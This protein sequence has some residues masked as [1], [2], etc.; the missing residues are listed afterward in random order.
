MSLRR[1]GADPRCD[2]DRALPITILIGS[3]PAK[4]FIDIFSAF[5]YYYI[6]NPQSPQMKG[7]YF[8]DL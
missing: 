3:G 8:F 5:L 6:N 7:I 1:W 4:T 2:E